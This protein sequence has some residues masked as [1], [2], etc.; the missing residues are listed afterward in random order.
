MTPDAQ[1]L[2][3]KI[4]AFDID[5]GPCDLPFAARLAREHGWS[6]THADRVIREYKRYVFLAM[7][8]DSPVCPSED[9]DAA[10]H[11]HLTY[12]K[13]YWKRFCGE[14]LGGPL[15]HNPTRGGASEGAKHLRMYDDTLAAYRTAFSEEPPTD[16]W[17]PAEQR[18]GADTR[19]RIVNTSRNWVI[20]KQPVKRVLQV[21]AAF[22]LAA[23]LLP[24][25]NGGLNPFA[26]RG[27]DY[28]FFLI[29]MMIGAVCIG[30]VIRSAMHSPGPRPEDDGESFTWEDAA[31][32]SG[33][34][35]RLTTAAIARLAEDGVVKIVEDRLEAGSTPGA[36]RTPIEDVVIHRLPVKKTDLKA[37]QDAVESRF[38][39]RAQELENEGFSLTP[40]QRIG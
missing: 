30:R 2:L 36:N 22:L 10:W 35:P 3:Q 20:P 39:R 33:G 29:P 17:P 28:F 38:G 5:G 12:T 15:H 26:L 11:L 16:I 14:V 23:V 19:Q 7:R 40:A 9:V 13:S 24:G 37:L 31:F 8:S 25:C 34:Y 6:R 18:F 32:L 27:T 1:D 21:A 4:E